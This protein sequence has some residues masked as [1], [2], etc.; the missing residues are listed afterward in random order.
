MLVKCALNGIQL[1]ISMTLR[2]WGKNWTQ[3]K[4]PT[5][6]AIKFQ[7]PFDF[8]P[9]LPL[10]FF[11]SRRVE[12]PLVRMR[13]KVVARKK[14]SGVSIAIGFT[15]RYTHAQLNGP[16]DGKRPL[17]LKEHKGIYSLK[18]FLSFKE[19]Y[20]CTLAFSYYPT[21]GICGTAERGGGGGAG[22]GMD[23]IILWQL[24]E[25]SG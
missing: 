20:R 15:E 24:V 21:P 1:K 5:A 16:F 7:L 9:H 14:R 18:L 13:R 10:W 3:Q 8:S 4:S 2:E 25:I 19:L 6:L 12:T 11:L 23:N 22:H 17:V